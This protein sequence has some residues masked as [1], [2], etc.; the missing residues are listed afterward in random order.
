MKVSVDIRMCK[1]CK[2]TIFSRKDYAA[3]T[4]HKPQ[5]QRLY[6]N[7]LQFEKGIRSILSIFQQSLVKLQDPDTPPTSQELADAAKVRKRLIDSF[8]KYDRLAKQIRDLPTDSI[9]QQKLQKNIHAQAS[10]F[11]H[12]HML[13]LKSLPKILK[14]A[15]PHGTAIPSHLGPRTSSSLSQIKYND[16]LETSSQV[17]SNSAISAL[18]VEEKELREKLIV[19][20]EQKFM[21]QEMVDE[22]RKKRRFDEVKALIGNV[23]DLDR[24]ID[25]LQGMLGN[26]DFESAY[27]GAALGTRVAN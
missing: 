10:N 18:E 11:L 26:L 23:E 21:V 8:G 9:S 25:T 12:I 20:E 14:H 24:E 4:S 3:E 27:N 15:S 16:S 19:V 17:S 22:A 5:D 6:E 7:L 13:P 1:E 2:S